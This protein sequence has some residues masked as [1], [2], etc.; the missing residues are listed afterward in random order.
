MFNEIYGQAQ[1]YLALTQHTSELGPI[2]ANIKVWISK[3][4]LYFESEFSNSS[5]LSDL[6]NAKSDL[7]VITKEKVETVASIIIAAKSVVDEVR[8]NTDWI[9]ELNK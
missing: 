7:S 8:G 9:A 5:L 2:E 1:N 4:V 6:V 3:S